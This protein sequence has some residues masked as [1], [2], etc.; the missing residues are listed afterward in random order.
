MII[1]ILGTFIAIFAFSILLES[2]K[3]YLFAAGIIGAVGGAVFLFSEKLGADAVLASFL[4]ALAIALV[5]HTFSRILKTPV[6]IFL[7]AGILPTVPGA[8]MYRIVYYMIEGDS[9]MTSHYFT[10]TL[11]IAGTIALAIFIVDTVFRVFQKGYKQNS[12][13]YVKKIKK[14]E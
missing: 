10:E 3:K 6:T 7:I 4:S 2:P 14:E 5:S 9:A 8:G 11:E 13:T 1:Q 12:L